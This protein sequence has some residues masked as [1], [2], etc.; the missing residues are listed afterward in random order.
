MDLCVPETKGVALED[1]AALFKNKNTSVRTISGI[2]TTSTSGLASSTSSS[3]MTTTRKDRVDV[4][5]KSRSYATESI[6]VLSPLQ[7]KAQVLATSH[8]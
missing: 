2:S 4:A 8:H 1:V 6:E 7:S 5:S 3:E